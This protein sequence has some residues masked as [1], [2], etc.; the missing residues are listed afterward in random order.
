MRY[1]GS[2]LAFLLAPAAWA[3]APSTPPV[4]QGLLPDAARPTAYRLDLTVLPDQDRFS[5]HAEIDVVLKAP[6]KS[7][8]LHGR[9][10]KVDARR[11][12]DGGGRQIAGALHPGRSAGRRASRFRQ[13][14]AGWHGDA[15]VRL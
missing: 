1:L 8:Y 11:W 6:A 13:A 2:A 14:A 10:L 7:L 5:G 3:V 9:D 12:R 15:G 4:P